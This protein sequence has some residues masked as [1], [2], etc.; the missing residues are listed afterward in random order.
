[1]SIQALQVADKPAIVTVMRAEA[2]M[3]GVYGLHVGG[4]GPHAAAATKAAIEECHGYRYDN[5]G[6]R[7][8][9]TRQGIERAVRRMLAAGVAI[10]LRM[11]PSMDGV[12]FDPEGSAA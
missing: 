4:E 3:Y 10:D 5:L 8:A 12:P 2:S 6:F 11:A 9:G 1:M 7:A